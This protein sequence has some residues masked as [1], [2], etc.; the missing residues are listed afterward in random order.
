[1]TVQV[2]RERLLETLRTNR[3]EH[4]LL[5]TEAMTA[6]RDA[7]IKEM[8]ARLRKIRAGGEI[9]KSFSNL[10]SPRSFESSFDKA[11]AMLEW[12]RA[13]TITLTSYDFER[14]VL[15]DWEWRGQFASS[16]LGYTVSK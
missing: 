5:Y 9:D 10:V 4:L 1:M 7:V 14:Y 3:A 2:P 11:I 8:S 13:D 15:N 6:Y 12:H 16:T